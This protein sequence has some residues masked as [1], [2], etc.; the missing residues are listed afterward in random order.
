MEK[1]IV[2]MATFNGE[3]YLEEQLQSLLNQ[4]EVDVKI[5][6]RDDGSTD[7]TLEILRRWEKEEKIEWYQGKHLNVQYGFYD[8]MRYSKKYDGNYYYAFC[9]QDDVWDQDKLYIAIKELKNIEAEVPGLYYCGQRLVDENLKFLSNHTLNK[10]RNLKTRFILSDIAGC[11]A[12]FNK[13]LRDKILEYRPDYMLM[14]DTWSLKV[15]LAVGGKV[16]IDTE[17]H[18]SYRQHGN[19][20]VGL[21]KG[22][23]ANL[24]QVRQYI[25]EYKVE[26]QMIELKK[27]YGKQIIPEYEKIV[28][29]VC[30]YKKNRKCR[31]KLLDKRC[32]DFCNKGLNLTYFIKVMLNKL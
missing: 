3:K 23:R 7:G 15:C 19:N 12:V 20:A 24:K 17:S 9:D 28:Y 14:H 31:K 11:T 25:M 29:Y 22:M 16:I 21:G 5:L 10:D 18:M 13:A 6:V 2:L 26:K 4:Q 27:G 30:N 32:I 1:V 8:L